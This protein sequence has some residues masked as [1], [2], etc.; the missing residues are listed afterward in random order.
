MR[1]RFVVA[2]AVN[3]EIT[4]CAAGAG[5]AE[6]KSSAI[7][8]ALVRVARNESLSAMMSVLSSTKRCAEIPRESEKSRRN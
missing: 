4:V 7:W 6:W 8:P 5:S 1:D 3:Y 2:L